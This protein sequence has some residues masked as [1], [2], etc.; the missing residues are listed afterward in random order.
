ML[1]NLT[2]DE[3]EVK[4]RLEI[5][6]KGNFEYTP[7]S[8][9]KFLQETGIY[10]CSCENLF[11][12]F[13]FEEFRKMRYD[14][15]YKI[16]LNSKKETFGIADSIEQIKEYYKEEIENKDEKYCLDFS[17]IWQQKEN[18]GKRVGWRWVNGGKYI[19]K[20][21]SK[22]EYLDDEHFG[23]DFKYVIRFTLHKIF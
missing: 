7:Q 4:R 16:S 2:V 22:Y 15:M 14:E 20:L 6:E 12:K 5:A 23:E 19:G 3:Q 8:D 11:A 10:Q 18:K 13:E 1:V 17:Y 21:N 9:P